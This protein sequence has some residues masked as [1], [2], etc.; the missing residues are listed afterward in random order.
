MDDLSTGLLVRQESPLPE[1]ITLSTEAMLFSGQVN[2]ISRSYEKT[3]SEH[4]G[5]TV[6]NDEAGEAAEAFRPKLKKA[7]AAKVMT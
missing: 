1:D 2:S 6:K 4:L 7:L 5:A 3:M